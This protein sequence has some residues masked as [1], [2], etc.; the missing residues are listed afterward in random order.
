MSANDLTLDRLP[1]T[2]SA[3]DALA[4]LARLAAPVTDTPAP[5]VAI[6]APA[7]GPDALGA[8][9]VG[10]IA[11]VLKLDPAEIPRSR[12][13]L[14]LGLD[15]ISATD[16]MSR[17]NED[18]GLSVPGTIL[19]EFDNVADLSAHLWEAHAQVL[20]AR[21]GV[22]T[23]AARPL[24]PEA[25]ALPAATVPAAGA[26]PAPGSAPTPAQAS[27]RPSMPPASG[28]RID[29][30]T[31]WEEIDAS[32]DAAPGSAARAQAL[33]PRGAWAKCA[34]TLGAY[35]PGEHSVALPDMDACVAFLRAANGGR[36]S[37]LLWLGERAPDGIDALDPA[38]EDALECLL[39]RED[40]SL[41]VCVPAEA[42]FG[43]LPVHLWRAIERAR[44]RSGC[45]LAVFAATIDARLAAE[46]R[47]SAHDML[48]IGDAP[49]IAAVLSRDAAARFDADALD[50]FRGGY[51]NEYA[52]PRL[53]E[54]A[55][56]L[57][58]AAGRAGEDSPPPAGTA[59]GARTIQ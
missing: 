10:L 4:L 17:F 42:A 11:E 7:G 59:A 51:R 24:A 40:R 8:A 26:Q 34:D 1:E 36:A 9:L 20:Q 29:V 23:V 30:K 12:P 55:V 33:P 46:L 54:F 18:H 43:Q 53:A 28:R 57:H 56:L 41:I 58:A 32:L 49:L 50:A 37:R 52:A 3:Q 27:A 48:F 25:D 14:E 31:M 19:F 15:S 47:H 45:Q 21:Y 16:L 6:A 5:A 13:L 2:L 39:D 44:T 38:A 22:P 35:R